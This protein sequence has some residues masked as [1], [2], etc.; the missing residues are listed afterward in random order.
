MPN[1]CIMRELLS[2]WLKK[3]R[4]RWFAFCAERQEF[5]EEQRSVRSS[6]VPRKPTSTKRTAARLPIKALTEPIKMQRTCTLCCWYITAG[7]IQRPASSGGRAFLPPRAPGTAARSL[8]A[9]LLVHGGSTNF[10]PGAQLGLRYK[11]RLSVT[12]R[13]ESSHF[14][15]IFFI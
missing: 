13:R 1:F 15:L 12:Y 7:E 11:S 9:P 6:E 2:D 10:Y 5:R 4:R 8:P 3:I 14:A